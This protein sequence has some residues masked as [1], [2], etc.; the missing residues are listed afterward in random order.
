MEDGNRSYESRRQRLAAVITECAEVRRYDTH[1]EREA[2][3]L[4]HAFLD[5]EESFDRFNRELL[6]ALERGGLTSEGVFD[7][8]HSIGEEF[9]HILYHLG[10]PQ[11]FRYLQDDQQSET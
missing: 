1:E 6:P 7:A 4:A 11:F 2:W 3:T 5:L 10:D 8:L 9:R